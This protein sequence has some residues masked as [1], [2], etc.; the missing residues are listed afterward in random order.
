M[1]TRTKEAK[2]S[3]EG[4]KVRIGR[5]TL[6]RHHGAWWQ[7]YRESRKPVRQRVGSERGEAER[8]AA[9][10]NAQVTRAAPTLF[11]FTPVPV[12]ELV[13]EFMTHHEVVRRSAVATI[14]RYRTALEHLV[15]YT[16]CDRADGPAHE[17][18][19]TRFVAFLRQ[20]RVSSNGHA[21]TPPRLLRDKGL[22]F[23]LEVCRSLYRFAAQRRHL[24][25][26][27][28]N[29]CEQVEIDRMRVDDAKRI[30][31]FDAQSELKSCGRAGI[32]SSQSS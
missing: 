32:G 2:R 14:R 28:Q 26:D 29:P 6:Y 15:A 1:G 12:Q 8:V 4:D 5:V 23:I 22:R 30:F 21:H 11:S 10:V 27:S 9:E 13:S 17:L 20:R 19:A 25:P 16:T 31:V 24:P 7:Y 18:G 3:R